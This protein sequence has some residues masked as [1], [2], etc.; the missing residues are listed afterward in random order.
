VQAVGVNALAFIDERYG[1]GEFYRA[2]ADGGVAAYMASLDEERREEISQGLDVAL[3]Y[4]LTWG[5]ANEPG[6]DDVRLL[7]EMGVDVSNE[8]ITRLYWLRL[9]RL[10]DTEAG[11]VMWAVRRLT[12]VAPGG[13]EG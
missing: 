10:E 6:E 4:C 5:V 12:Y 7:K 2:T 8:K 13:E 11:A 1:L 3:N 9:L